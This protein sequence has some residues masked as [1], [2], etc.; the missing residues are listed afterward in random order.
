L[1]R[2][3]Y[4]K[5]KKQ[6]LKWNISVN[7]RIRTPELRVLDEE[8]EF[9][10][11]LTRNEALA[12]AKEY[13]LDLVEVAP[14]AKPPVAKIIDFNKHLYQLAKKSKNDKKG[15][16]E[17]KEVKVGLFMAEHD[18]DRMA[19]RAQ[20]FILEGNQVRISLWLKGRELGKKEDAR[21]FINNFVGKIKDVKVSSEPLMHGKVMR[22]VISYEKQK[23]EQ[24]KN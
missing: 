12:K 18:V 1:R 3:R 14:K 15:K 22:V 2:R 21:K 9:V 6:I 13:G 10:G 16:T 23:N 8:G 24:A 17:T 11:L 20:K 4:S 7:E 5:S 19:Q